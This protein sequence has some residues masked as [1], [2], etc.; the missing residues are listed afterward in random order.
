[1]K[2]RRGNISL[3]STSR[4]SGLSLMVQSGHS[5]AT[6]HQWPVMSPALAFIFLVS[7][8]LCGVNL[9]GPL[10][11]QAMC[12]A[13][14]I[15]GLPHGTFDFQ[16]LRDSA[17]NSRQ[18]LT[19]A[20]ALYLALAGATYS[21]W[22]VDATLSLGAFLT[23]SVVHFSEDWA[24]ESS[25]TQHPTD[26]LNIAM[27]VSLIS[28]PA[29]SHSDDLRN[30]FV[31]L[32]NAADATY[33]VDLLML[34]SPVACGVAMV[35]LFADFTNGQ[36]RR[37]ISSLIMLLA[38]VALPPILGFALF[39]CLA[40]SRRHFEEGIAALAASKVSSWQRMVVPLTVAAAGITSVMLALQ[41]RVTFTDSVSA[42]TFMTL[43][44]LTVPHMLVPI[45]LS[46]KPSP[47]FK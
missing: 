45:L 18:R 38:M 19:Y 25:P 39:F 26:F 14:L 41:N 32:T 34:I 1:M 21:L 46:H 11:T 42:A 17:Q 29:L 33:L 6:A 5:S 20:V 22:L 8:S 31:G 3:V 28:L 27:P 13:L 16:I 15:A 35:K 2:V 7:V 37:A 36:Q 12:F 43:S 10:M 30:I 24:D 4:L 23:I 9:G 44:I 40:H 47:A